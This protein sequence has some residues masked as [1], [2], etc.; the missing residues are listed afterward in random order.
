MLLCF[1]SCVEV[2]AFLLNTLSSPRDKVLLCR[3]GWLGPHTGPPTSASWMV[4]LKV[5]ATM[6]GLNTIL[7]R[8]NDKL[9]IQT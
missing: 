9:D 2:V 7:E 5:C 6:P 1:E 8:I 4:G 3:F